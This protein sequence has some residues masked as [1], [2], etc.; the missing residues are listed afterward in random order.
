M[1]HIAMN[2]TTGE[3]M[4]TRTGNQLKRG[5]AIA[6]HFNRKYW[7]VKGKWIFAHGSDA[8]EKIAMKMKKAL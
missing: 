4:E 6:E 2:I 5:V 3:V 8:Q 1:K 7:N